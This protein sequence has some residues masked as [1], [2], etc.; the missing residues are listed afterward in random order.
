MATG[1]QGF[2]RRRFLGG[3]LEDCSRPPG[4]SRRGSPG[5]RLRR[6]GGRKR[7]GA[8]SP[9]WTGWTRPEGGHQDSKCPAVLPPRPSSQRS[10]LDGTPEFRGSRAKA[11]A[12]CWPCTPRT[13]RSQQARPRLER[14]RRNS[15]GARR[16]AAFRRR[17]WPGRA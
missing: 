13:P 11:D 17:S 3:G 10:L 12:R 15:R 7:A 8:C 9:R 14:P 6:Q 16:P 5:R 1:L 2:G 4:R